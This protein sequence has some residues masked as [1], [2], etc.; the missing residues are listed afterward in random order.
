MLREPG[1]VAAGPRQAR[2]KTGTHWIGDLREYDW[3]IAGRLLERNQGQRRTGKE[4]IRLESNQLRGL[5]PH[6]LETLAATAPTILHLNVLSRQP[7]ELLEPLSK[8]IDTV[9]SFRIIFGNSEQHADARHRAALLRARRERPHSCRAAEQR[10][11]LTALYVKH[12]L[13]PAQE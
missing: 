13:P 8:C 1:D 7:A 9:A 3:N 2:D 11:E 4:H 5:S 6:A 12:G 10:D